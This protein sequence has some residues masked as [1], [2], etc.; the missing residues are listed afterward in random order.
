MER[1]NTS[2]DLLTRE[3]PGI[4]ALLKS[5]DVIRDDIRTIADNARPVLN[6][7]R[8]LTD[9]ELA[10]QLSVSR[11]TLF[12]WRSEEI[13]G[14]IQLGGKILYRQSDVLRLMEKN[15]HKPYERR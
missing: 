13:I 9:K 15:F 8:Y 10:E 14:Y 3:S 4:K 7:E 11:R 6:G 1:S 12:E 5:L 2:G